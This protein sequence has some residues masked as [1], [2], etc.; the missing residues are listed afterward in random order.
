MRSGRFADC[1]AQVRL[2]EHVH[3]V[4]AN[5]LVDIGGFFRV[6]MVDKRG[7]KIHDQ[8]F[9]RG[10]AGRFLDLLRPNRELMIYLEG[11]HQ[12]NAFGQNLSGHT[13]EQSKHADIARFDSRHRGEQQDH[14]QESGDSQSNEPRERISVHIDDLAPSVT[15]Y[16]HDSSS[17]TRF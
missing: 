5:L 4:W 9:G 17:P 1:C 11:I 8:T 13:P 16:C 10:Y 6:E 7:V 3:V 12:V 14:K 2:N 15:I